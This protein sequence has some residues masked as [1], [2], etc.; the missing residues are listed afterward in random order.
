LCQPQ[1]DSLGVIYYRPG[2]VH[3]AIWILGLVTSNTSW[4]TCTLA[5]LHEEFAKLW[6]HFWL[7]KWERWPWDCW[8]T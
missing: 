4:N 1:P 8:Y 6:V 7:G 3:H 2:Y 5:N